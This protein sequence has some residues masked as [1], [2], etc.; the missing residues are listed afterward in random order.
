MSFCMNCGKQLKEGDA[1]CSLCGNPVN[2][3]P[4]VQNSNAYNCNII[5]TGNK[6]LAI[7]AIVFAFIVPFIGLILGIIATIVNRKTKLQTL[8]VVA[9]IVSILYLIL[10]GLAIY[11]FMVLVPDFLYNTFCIPC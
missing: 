10:I 7:A 11:C 9:L 8:S 1:F 5:D 3:V 6:P 2:S 4:G